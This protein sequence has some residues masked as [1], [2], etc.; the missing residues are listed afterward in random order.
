MLLSLFLLAMMQG[1]TP[2][3]LTALEILKTYMF[4]PTMTVAALAGHSGVPRYR[5]DN[6]MP[7]NRCP[8]QSI[9]VDMTGITNA[10]SS[11][12]DLLYHIREPGDRLSTV[13]PQ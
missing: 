9:H 7:N 5:F 13:L 1:T 10:N 3:S 8:A 6:R 4:K 11:G 12:I 2:P